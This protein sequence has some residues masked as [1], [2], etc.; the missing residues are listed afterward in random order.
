MQMKRKLFTLLSLLVVLFAVTALTACGGRTEPGE[1]LG[2][3]VPTIGQGATVFRFEVT[4]GA[5]EVSAWYVHT[6]EATV[7]AA[8]VEVGLVSGEVGQWGLFVDTVN[9]HTNTDGH[10]WAF[11][12]NGEMAMTGVDS[13]YIEPGVVYAFV[14]ETF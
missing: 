8:L 9:G 13:T 10:W 3:N 1:Y 7:G 11:W 14:Y 12:I 5:G 2:D 4:D 6:N